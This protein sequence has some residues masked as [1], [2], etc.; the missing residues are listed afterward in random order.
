MKNS[1][2]DWVSVSYTGKYVV[3]NGCVHGDDEAGYSTCNDRMQVYYSETGEKAGPVWPGYGRPS[4]QD[5]TID[6]NGDD[7]VVGI[8]KSG[9]F[10]GRTIMRRL[11]DGEITP[12]GPGGSHTGARNTGRPGWV[13]I[14]SPGGIYRDEVT[15]VQCKHEGNVIERLGYVPNNTT[16]YDS[17]NYGSVSPDGTRFLA[18]SNWGDPSGTPVQ[19]YVVDVRDIMGSETRIKTTRMPP[20]PGTRNLIWEYGFPVYYLHNPVL[21]TPPRDA[22]GRLFS[23]K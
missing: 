10:S 6:E 11:H 4:H 9:D 17:Q 23:V 22:A 3:V 8:A 5:F 20:A 13:Y 12:L 19:A 7:I 1:Y 21:E 15:A 18:G 14:Q 2:I 16:G